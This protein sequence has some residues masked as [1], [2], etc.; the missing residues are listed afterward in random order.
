[1][2]SRH[3]RSRSTFARGPRRA[4]GWNVGPNGDSGTVNGSSV[5]LLGGTLIADLDD[6][7]IVRTRGE[8]SISLHTASAAREGF[9]WAM[10]M[11][12]VTENAAGIGVTAVPDPIIDMGWDGWFVFEQGS[13]LSRSAFANTD[14][15]VVGSVERRI[16]D[17]KAM[18]KTHQSDVIICVLGFTELGTA[19]IA[20][21]VQSRLLGKL[22]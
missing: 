3:G 7:T 11:C 6:E 5:V 8:I 4:V 18:R 20:I 13:M 1:M 15:N 19:T 14:D 21:Q 16:F 22:A 2:A 17:F 10:G 12:V 9:N